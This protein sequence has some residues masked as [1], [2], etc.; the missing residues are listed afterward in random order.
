M[1]FNGTY[2]Y[3][4]VERSACED[5]IRRT[6]VVVMAGPC[7]GINSEKPEAQLTVY[8]NP[9]S[10]ALHIE[11]GQAVTNNSMKVLLF[12]ALGQ[13][14]LEAPVKEQSLLLDLEQLPPGVYVVNLVSDTKTIATQKIVRQ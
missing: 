12:N 1:L 5:S 9:V 13:Q 10:G 6:A 3:Y 11:M 4:V 14:V 2:T 7:T 8:P